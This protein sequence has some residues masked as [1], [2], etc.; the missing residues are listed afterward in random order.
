MKQSIIVILV[1]VFFVFSCKSHNKNTSAS[2]QKNPKETQLEETKEKTKVEAH[3]L[4]EEVNSSEEEQ[5]EQGSTSVLSVKLEPEFPT[6][7]DDIKVVLPEGFSGDIIWY[8]N[9]ERIIGETGN[10]LSS[11]Y[12]KRGDVVKVELIDSS[13]KRYEG[14]VRIYNANPQIIVDNSDVYLDDS[15]HYPI[16]VSDPDG[17]KVKVEIVEAPEGYSF[18]P[19]N[20]TIVIPL[21]Q[22]NKTGKYLI[23]FT[24]KAT[25][26]HGGW[27]KKKIGYTLNVQRETYK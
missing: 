24:V 26:G 25:D 7:E 14:S 21:D 4:E 10:V 5:E 6:T 9:D 16:K 3:Q 17:D 12:F 20:N 27:V 23:T 11:S 22:Y 18:D 13:G 19:E 15:L 8:V 1:L 2:F